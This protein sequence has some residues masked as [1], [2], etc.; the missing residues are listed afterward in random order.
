MITADFYHGL[1]LISI[2]YPQ[3]WREEERQGLKILLP[4]T[5]QKEII[6]VKVA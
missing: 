3:E 4:T 1:N 6:T 2:L 5:D